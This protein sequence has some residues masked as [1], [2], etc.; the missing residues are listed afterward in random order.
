MNARTLL[1]PAVIVAGLAVGFWLYGG[2]RTMCETVGFTVPA[3]LF[4]LLLSVIL[5]LILIVLPLL[6]A[7]NFWFREK[8]WPLSS[9]FMTF[10]VCLLIGSFASEVWILR[11]EAKFEDE[12]KH[13]D[14]E[15]PYSR[16]RAWPN[17]TTSLVFVPNVGIHA[18]D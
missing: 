15:T 9:L 11:D 18:T 2:G 12:V 4:G 16:S 17:R 8:A 14:P 1:L 13:L 3:F 5:P 6:I 10:A 7:K